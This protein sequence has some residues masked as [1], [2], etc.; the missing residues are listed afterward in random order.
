MLSIRS[1]PAPLAAALEAAG[2]RSLWDRYE[3]LVSR[4]PR[5][6]EAPLHWRWQTLAP[7]VERAVIEAGTEDAERRVLLLTHSAFPGTVHTTRNLSAGIQILQPGE[8]AR[9]HRHTLGA[10]RFVM[11]GEGAATFV[12]GERC[13][14][15]PGDLILTPAWAWHEHVNEGGKR[16][17]WFDGLDLPLAQHL[18]TVFFEAGP[19]RDTQPITSILRHDRA[20]AWA[21]LVRTPAAQDGSREFRYCTAG[22]GPVLPTIDCRLLAPGTER[23]TCPV[24]STASSICVVAQGEGESVVGSTRMRWRRNDVFTIPQWH[25]AS[26][27]ATSDGAVLFQMSD[28]ALLEPLGYLREERGEAC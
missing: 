27:R 6:L 5:A 8:R 16:V 9:P 11:E 2:L 21:A 22:G 4:E 24:R 20:A 15:Q 28:R 17:V 10:L 26:H 18:D 19:V 14:M 12:D 25:W 7:L 3:P 1:N 13:A 23:P